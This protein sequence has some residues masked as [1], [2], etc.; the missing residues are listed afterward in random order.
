RP[1][2]RAGRGRTVTP[3]D[4]H[5]RSPALCASCTVRRRRPG[6]IDRGN[7]PLQ[8]SRTFP[9]VAVP[10][11]SDNPCA[12]PLARSEA[13]LRPLLAALLLLFGRGDTLVEGVA[14]GV[15]TDGI[16]TVRG[17]ADPQRKGLILVG[18]GKQAPFFAQGARWQLHDILPEDSSSPPAQ[19]PGQ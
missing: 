4:R 2:G 7:G 5:S 15:L 11:S 19:Q 1:V 16:G 18:E 6:T 17:T 12:P 14:R 9:S 3:L 8:P 13:V 10:H